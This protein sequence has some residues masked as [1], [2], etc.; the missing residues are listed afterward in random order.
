VLAV[1]YD[2]LTAH[3]SKINSSFSPSHSTS[4]SLAL[5]AVVDAAGPSSCELVARRIDSTT[6]QPYKLD[7]EDCAVCVAPSRLRG[8]G[9]ECRWT[10]GCLV[11]S[12][13]R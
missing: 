2:G 7:G 1:Q 12:T 5:V 10:G 9:V 8:I 6:M 3:I 4:V 11:G 13:H